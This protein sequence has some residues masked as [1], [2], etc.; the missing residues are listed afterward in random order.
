MQNWD[1]NISFVPEAII[2]IYEITRYY[3]IQQP[4]LGKEF[5]EYINESLELLKI[6]PYI[7]KRFYKKYRISILSKFPFNIVYQ[8]D[9]QGKNVIIYIVFHQSR[10]LRSIKKRLN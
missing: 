3:E 7:Y 9:K 4:G 10:N 2:D 8:I 1:F 5:Y 6:F